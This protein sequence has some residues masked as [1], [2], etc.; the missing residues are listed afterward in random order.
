MILETEGVV[1]THPPRAFFTKKR[2]SNFW[3]REN[4]NGSLS[5]YDTSLAVSDYNR[6]ARQL[7]VAL[8]RL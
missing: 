5:F 3:R 1:Q 4:P 7:S 6:K 8:A 2:S